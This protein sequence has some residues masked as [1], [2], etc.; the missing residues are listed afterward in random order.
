M[1]RKDNRHLHHFVIEIM[2]VLQKHSFRKNIYKIRYKLWIEK[3][4]K[5]GK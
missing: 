1:Q 3:Y 4:N 2:F 5:Y